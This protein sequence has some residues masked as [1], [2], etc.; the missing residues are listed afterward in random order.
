MKKEIKLFILL[1]V[2]SFQ[3]HASNFHAI[4]FGD[5]SE[6]TIAKLA[7]ADIKMMTA[8][9]KD[10]AKSTGQTLKLT[11]LKGDQLT[12]ENLEET[13]NQ[14]PPGSDDTIFFFQTS[15]GFRTDDHT[16]RWPFLLYSSNFFAIDF[17]LINELLLSKKP[18]LLVSVVNACNSS[19]PLNL[20]TEEDKSS[21]GLYRSKDSPKKW[22]KVYKKLFT[23]AKG[24]I[25][26]SSSKPGQES[27]GTDFGGGFFTI[28]FIKALRKAATGQIQPDWRKIMNETTKETKSLAVLYHCSQKPQFMILRDL[29]ER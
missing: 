18:R 29:A 25:I 26:A 28:N 17:E 13:F 16:G 27:Y 11:I 3:I 24:A 21:E 5:T 1:L 12:L 6:E 22:G 7:R 8:L 9:V 20:I 23:G 2:L 14:I 10:I 19:L 15:H 4:L